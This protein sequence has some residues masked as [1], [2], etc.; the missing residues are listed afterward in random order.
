MELFSNLIESASK[1]VVI[2]KQYSGGANSELDR[3]RTC[4]MAIISETKESESLD[5]DLVKRITGGG[6]DK[7]NSRSLY[8][9]DSAWAPH[10]LPFIVTNNLPKCSG[11]KALLDRILSFNFGAEFCS[12]PKQDHQRKKDKD[13]DRLW[14]DPDVKEAALAW[15]V[16]GGARYYREGLKIPKK[17]QETSEEFRK[18][19][20]SIELFLADCT[21]KADPESFVGSTELYQRYVQYCG[22]ELYRESQTKFGIL[23][24]RIYNRGKHPSTRIVIYYGIR[25]TGNGSNES[26]L[27]TTVRF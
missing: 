27:L 24:G 9:N 15:I 22:T 7:I 17:V 23:L 21:E 18:S 20:N 25:L 8:A 19:R 14:E 1:H 2:E 12:E 26:N 5:E 3:L 6:K 11:D 16:K 4:R 10:F 13:I